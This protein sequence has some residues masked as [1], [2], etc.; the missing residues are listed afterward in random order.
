MIK[1]CRLI[2]KVLFLCA[3]GTAT[4]EWLAPGRMAIA[5]S[6]DHNLNDRPPTRLMKPRLL[7]SQSSRQSKY[8]LQVRQLV[9]RVGYQPGGGTLRAARIGDTLQKIG[10]RLITDHQSGAVLRLGESIAQVEVA[11]DTEL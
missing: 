6:A 5:Q 9:G 8:Q 3:I 11:T 10:D 4:G 2:A 7:I 1:M